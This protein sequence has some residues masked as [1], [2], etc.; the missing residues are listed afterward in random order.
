MHRHAAGCGFCWLCCALL[1][2]PPHTRLSLSRTQPYTVR[3]P[4][5]LPRLAARAAACG[6][7][8]ALLHA[9]PR[10]PRAHAP[11]QGDWQC[12]HVL[13]PL[14]LNHLYRQAGWKVTSQ[15][16]QLRRGS[17]PLAALITL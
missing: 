14:D 3:G 2:P 8:A 9:G 11:Y 16:W 17:C 5:A 4:A 12:G 10:A 1:T 7:A 15:V 13:F 6:V